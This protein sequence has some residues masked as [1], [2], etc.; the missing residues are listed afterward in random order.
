MKKILK[1]IVF[2]IGCW[3]LGKWIGYFIVQ[4]L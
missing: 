1:D 4:N 3:Q 2:I